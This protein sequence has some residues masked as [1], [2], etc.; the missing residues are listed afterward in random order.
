VTHESLIGVS[1]GVPSVV[2]VPELRRSLLLASFVSLTLFGLLGLA[3][4]HGWLGTAA[5]D[6]P[7]AGIRDWA[8]HRPWLEDSLI[9]VE[10]L[11]ST[12]GLTV[13]TI[14]VVGFLLLRRQFRAGGLVL[15]VMLAARELSGY[16][17]E[18]FGRDRPV[19]QDSDFL[20]HAS[21][22]PSG[23]ATGVAAFGGLVVVLAI[24][25]TRGRANLRPVAAV[26][27]VGVLIVCADRLLLGRHY[28]TDLVGGV[29]LATSLVLLGT[30]LLAVPL[31]TREN[32]EGTSPVQVT[33]LAQDELVLSRS[34]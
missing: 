26:V 32:S 11:F 18:L 13:A 15:V 33:P 12:R 20:H 19:W 6:S 1:S 10:R 22:Y 9:L 27:T 5:L 14:V 17:K 31:A 2:V 16:T 7:S 4:N 23:H 8:A 29:L 28:P 25:G 21:S 3:A 30:A 34:A 24:L